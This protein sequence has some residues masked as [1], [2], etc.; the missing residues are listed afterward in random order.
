MRYW[1][2]IAGMGVITFGIRGSVIALFGRVEIPPH[3]RRSL[4][5]VPPAVL[6]ALVTPALVRPAGAVDLSFTN[7][8]LVAG[9]VAAVVAWKAKSTVLTIASGMAVLWALRALL[10]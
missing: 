8:H 4:R 10:P 6:T 5:F 7:T 3:L 2:L 9:I 1:L